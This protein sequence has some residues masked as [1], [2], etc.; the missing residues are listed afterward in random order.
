[1]ERELI[2]LMLGSTRE[3]RNCWVWQG[4]VTTK[5]YAQTKTKP[6]EHAHRFMFR[7]L[8]GEIP[9]WAVLHHICGNKRCLNPTHLEIKHPTEHSKHHNATKVCRK[10]G[11]PLV[12]M[13]RQRYNEGWR[14]IRRCPRCR[15]EY[16]RAMYLRRKK[17]LTT[18]QKGR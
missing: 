15:R 12:V 10:C 9:E 3:R 1:M 11:G 13:E 18:R 14:D 7:L 2:R 4:S 17:R 5:G 8:R 6:A 16:L